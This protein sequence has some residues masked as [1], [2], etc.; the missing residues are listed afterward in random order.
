MIDTPDLVGTRVGRYDVLSLLGRGGMGAVYDAVD[1]T[2][3]RHVALKVLPTAVAGDAKRLARFVQEARAA[4]ALNHPNV[5]AIYEIGRELVGS[6]EIY[7]IAMEKVEGRSLRAV[8]SGSRLPI[9]QAIELVAQISDAIAAA[10]S[11]GIVHRDLK[12]ENVV[13]SGR[14]T[15]KVLDFGLAKLRLD[16]EIWS[17]D[18][19]TAIRSTASGVILGTVG[20]MSPE[21]AQGK[22]AD[23]RSDIFSLGCILYEAVAGHRAFAAGSS[24]ETLS[25]IINAV[26]SPLRESSPSAPAELQRMV[27]K[28][29]AKHADERYQ[30]AKELSIDLRAMLRETSETSTSPPRATPR[31]FAAIAFLVV[32]AVLLIAA[33]AWVARYR[34]AS[35]ALEPSSL[36]MTVRRVTARGNVVHAAI[37]PDGRFVAFSLLDGPIRLRQ[38]ATGQELELYR[39]EGTGVWGVT[40]TPDGNSV[41]FVAKDPQNPVGSCFRIPSIGGR[42]EHLFD[43]IDS[44]PSFSPDGSQVTFVR[45]E[46]P[47]PGASALVVAN[48]DGSS[49]RA[50]AIRRSPERFTPNSF[51]APSWSPDGK[52]IATAVKRDADPQTCKLVLI[53]PKSGAE[54]V[55]LDRNWPFITMAAWLP[56]GGGIITVASSESSDMIGLQLWLVSYPSGDA[57]KITGELAAYR[58]VTIAADGSQLVSIVIE[59][60]AQMWSVPLTDPRAAKKIS[61]GRFDGWRGLTLTPDGRIVFTSVEDRVQTLMISNRDGT[62]RSRLTRDDYSNQYPAAL[63][64]GVAYVSS[65]PARN[66][67]CVIGFDGEERR[68]LASHVDASPIAISRD[69]AWLIFRRNRR[70]WKMPMNGGEAKQLLTDVSSSP[71]WS[72]TGDRIAV[73]L[74]DPDIYAARLGVI[75]AADGRLLWQAPLSGV[76]VGSTIRWLP[77]SSGLLVNGGPEDTRNLWVHPFTGKPRRLTEFNDQLSFFWDLSADGKD[78]VIAR[79][80]ISRDAVLITDFR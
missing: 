18:G 77:D 65:T 17:L 59:A 2:L 13:M 48:I 69:G 10:H 67:V 58:G 62:E 32:A 1:S 78:A 61:A 60:N 76:R 52:W 3:G 37:S 29:M 36:S 73:L 31:R 28:A 15:P 75:S 55:L 68:V 34:S 35:P 46:F 38:L 25:A 80:T 49:Y 4:S 71:E 24:V 33:I 16:D 14:G 42:P 27:S 64:D 20:Y 44:A 39:P 40:F 8:L 50:I 72:P 30:S 12:P 22:T 26:P 51:T 9:P 11:A 74:G 7:F 21:Q 6:Q 63:R 70:L 23:H 54:K 19:E 79:A 57:K 66:E 47:S 43:G 41:V 53:D 45:G 56:D 5:V